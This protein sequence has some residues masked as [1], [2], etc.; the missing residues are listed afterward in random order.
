MAF[1]PISWDLMIGSISDTS[2]SIL[3]TISNASIW[4]INGARKWH[5]LLKGIL[6]CCDLLLNW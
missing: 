3:G 2:A 1:Y 6:H 5:Q 4:E